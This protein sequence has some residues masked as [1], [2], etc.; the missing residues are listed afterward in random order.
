MSAGPCR[1]IKSVYYICLH[2]D[3]ARA[4]KQITPTGCRCRM[5]KA[6]SMETSNSQELPLI[7]FLEI[8]ISLC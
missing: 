7:T 4:G 6:V 2:G 1:M 5:I 3:K 8:L